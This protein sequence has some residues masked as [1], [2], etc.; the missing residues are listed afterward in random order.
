MQKRILY[1]LLTGLLGLASCTKVNDLSDDAEIISFAITNISPGIELD[2]ENII[3]ND[4]VVLI[5]LEFG[6][7]NFPLTISTDIRLSKTTDDAISANDQKLNLKEFTFENIYDSHNFYLISESG[8]PHPAE[9][10]LVDKLNAEIE[11]ESINLTEEEASV[12]KWRNNIR[13]IL[14]KNLSW[15]LIITPVFTKTEDAEYV[16]YNDGDSFTFTSPSDTEKHITLKAANGDERTWNIQLVS[17]IENSDFE[18]WINEGSKSVN[19]DPTPGE[20]LGWA[21]A[22]NS[23]VQGTK[24]VLYNGGKAAE[25]TTGLQNLNSLGIGELITAGTIFTGKFKMKISALN[26]P[27]AMTHF[28]I[29]FT[30]KPISISVDAKYIAGS[31]LQQSVK[32]SG[33]Y[34]L[35]NLT[36]TDS[37]RIWVKIL[38]WGGKGALEYHEKPVP[39]LTI[40]GEGELIF[41]GKNQTLK[42]WHTYTIPI[43]YNS[44]YNHIEPTH[45][46]IVMTSRRKGDIFIGA[47]GSKLTAD[48]VVI[49]Y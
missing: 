27:P 3:I 30:L 32:E 18:L 35:H 12:S 29:P 34:K 42:N 45:I 7:K 17:S 44:A 8:K 23:F 20:G 47:V 6:R 49:N 2:R 46:A 25:M 26:N 16:D 10:K 43:E 38:H 9:I 4:N 36:G 39:D 21:T 15:P 28:G 37:G 24:P 11:L 22:N 1:F 14:K 48:N 41:D 33:K 13:I 31:Q 40:L 5:P 19:I